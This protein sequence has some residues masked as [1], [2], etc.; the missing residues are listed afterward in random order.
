METKAV[1]V[2][3]M[4][5]FAKQFGGQPWFKAYD[6][7][8]QMWVE[9]GFSDPDRVIFSKE[10]FD[11]YTE[12]KKGLIMQGQGQA[13]PDMP[14]GGGGP[15]PNEMSPQITEQNPNMPPVEGP[16]VNPMDF[17]GMPQR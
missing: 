7:A 6:I 10:E 3:Q 14:T 12:F 11:K 1:K 13:S 5:E 8:R 9:M 2:A 4:G 15:P 16:G 17:Q